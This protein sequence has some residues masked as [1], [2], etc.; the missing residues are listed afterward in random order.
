MFFNFSTVS[1]DRPVICWWSG[2]VTSA[3]ACWLAVQQFGTTC[4]KAV[5]LDT[6]NED[7]DTERFR[8]ECEELYG[9]PIIKIRNEEYNS[10]ED[11]WRR[12]NSLNVATG[13]ICSTDLKRKTREKYQRENPYS[14]QVFG[15]EADSKEFNRAKSLAANYP[16]SRPI[17]PLIYRMISKQTCIKIL[18]QVG[19]RAPQVYHLGFQ[20]NNCFKTGCVQGGIGYWQKMRIEFPE[21]FDK[22]AALEHELTDKKG[23][24]VTMLK[25]QGKNGGLVFL[26]PHPTYPDVKDMSMMRGRPPKSMVDCNGMCGVNDMS[27]LD[28]S[29][30]NFQEE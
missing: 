12:Y 14:F 4:V 5:M 16:E 22:M 9:I 25:D 28:Q 19:I 27:P 24:P 10:I 2:G 13:A 23:S 29:E 8:I 7:E 20:N 15:F 30:I 6:M 17:F 21:K 18:E 3:V 26:K 11:V 1:P